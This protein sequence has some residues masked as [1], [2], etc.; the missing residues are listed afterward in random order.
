MIKTGVYRAKNSGTTIYSDGS[1]F[2]GRTGWQ[3]HKDWHERLMES[4][5]WIYL[6]AFKEYVK[7]L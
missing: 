2:Y 4:D 1:R 3:P 6:G 5:R 7:K